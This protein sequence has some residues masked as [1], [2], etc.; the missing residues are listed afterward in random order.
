L[1][2]RGVGFGPFSLL[3]WNVVPEK[4]AHQLNSRL[5]KLA[6]TRMPLLESTARNYVALARKLP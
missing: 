4:L 3:R 6:D 2:A 1:H 5:Q